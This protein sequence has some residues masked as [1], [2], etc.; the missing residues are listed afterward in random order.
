[1]VNLAMLN[2]LDEVIHEG[3]SSVDIHTLYK[4]DGTVPDIFLRGCGIPE[5]FIAYKSSFVGSAIE[6]Y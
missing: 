6:F 2:G 1:M 5:E 4:T 3:P